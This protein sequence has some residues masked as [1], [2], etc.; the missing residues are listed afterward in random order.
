[1]WAYGFLCITDDYGI[2]K[3]PYSGAIWHSAIHS[4]LGHT[5]TADGFNFQ[6]Q[7]A[8]FQTN[9]CRAKHSTF[10]TRLRLMVSLWC[11]FTELTRAF[12]AAPCPHGSRN[13]GKG[14]G[15][16]VP[17]MSK[18]DISCVYHRWRLFAWIVVLLVEKSLGSRS[19]LGI[20]RVNKIGFHSIRRRLNLNITDETFI[21]ELHLHIWDHT[22]NNS[23]T[24]RGFLCVNVTKV[25]VIRLARKFFPKSSKTVFIWGG[26]RDMIHPLFELIR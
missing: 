3:W 23:F 5:Y 8:H 11:W 6:E 13:V 15:C 22:K 18:R 9:T 25:K 12:A 1:M 20:S 19:F 21:L 16:D 4:G 17:G 24:E 2:D 7:L 10:L 26:M 14:I